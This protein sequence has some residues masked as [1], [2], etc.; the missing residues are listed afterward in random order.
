MKPVQS[1]TQA[2]LADL[3]RPRPAAIIASMPSASA[4]Y[5]HP[6]ESMPA[7]NRLA[8]TRRSSGETHPF[9]PGRATPRQPPNTPR[10]PGIAFCGHRRGSDLV[11]VKVLFPPNSM[12]GRCSRR[13]PRKLPRNSAAGSELWKPTDSRRRMLAAHVNCPVRTPASAHCQSQSGAAKGNRHVSH[14]PTVRGS[15]SD[16]ASGRTGRLPPAWPCCFGP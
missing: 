12:L 5:S 13:S 16:Q 11:Q 10:H 1:R 7:Q 14:P 3:P 15:L 2:P 8:G 4:E 9:P 6:R